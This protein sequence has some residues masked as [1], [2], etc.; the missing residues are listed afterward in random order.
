MSFLQPLLLFGLPLVAIPIIIHLINQRRFQTVRWG[1]MMFSA[2][3]QPTVARVR[4][5]Q[6]MAHHGVPDAGHCGA[7]LAIARPL[8]SGGLGSPRA[9]RADTTIVCRPLSSMQER[10]AGSAGSKL[11]TGR[12]QLRA[13]PAHAGLGPL[14]SDRKHDPPAARLESPDSL[15]SSPATETGQQCERY[16]GNAAGGARLHSVEHS[17]PH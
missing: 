11:E 17:G 9:A 5:A 14:G 7:D 6:A 1:A 10:G 15:L 3:G 4:A 2:G 13:G 8:A 16:P 12:Q